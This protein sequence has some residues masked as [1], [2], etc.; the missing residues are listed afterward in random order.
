M[1]PWQPASGAERKLH[2][3]IWSE[4]IDPAIVAEFE[5]EY[6]CRVILDLYE[7]TESM[8][9][10]LTHGGD[11]LYD[12]VVPSDNIVPVLIRRGLLAP[13]RHENLPN[14]RHLADRF[15]RPAYDPTHRYTV[16]YQWGTMGLLV[17]THAGNMPEATWGLLFDSKRQ[18]GPFV[19]LDS[20]RD[21]FA[22]ALRYLGCSV[23]TTNPTD[24][25]RAR[26]LLIEA[27]KRAR[28]FDSSVGGM[29]KVLSGVARAAIVYS[30]EAARAM[31][32][33]TNLT[34]LLPR[35]GSILWVD[36]LVVPARSPHRDLAEQF[37]NFVLEPRRAARI[38][39]YTRFA[40]CNETA[41][42]HLQAEDLQNPAIYPPEEVLTRLEFLHDLG[43]GLR[44][45]DEAWTQLKAR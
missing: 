11:A 42:G 31:N 7:D 15:R 16:P 19:L 35:E 18:P 3:F 4:Y 6:Q 28:G 27:R 10:R 22:A 37:I 21:M 33:D 34:Y 38:A 43:P 17:R 12:V 36:N 14:L 13:L 2:L 40:T 32:V 1:A 45:Y 5:R 41:R 29:N 23:N 24:L 25:R 20:P 39:Q 8:L 26:D 30:G 9:A 44:L